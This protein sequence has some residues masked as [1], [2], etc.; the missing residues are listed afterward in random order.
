MRKVLNK[1]MNL[2]SRGYITFSDSN[3]KCQ[4]LQIKMSGGEQKSDIEYIEPYGFTSRP[5]DGAEAVALFLDGDKSHGV[6]LTTGDRRYRITSLKKGEVAIY[7]DEGDAIIF[8]R[9]NEI[10]VKTKKFIVNADDAIELNTKNLVVSAS[11]GTQF[12]TPLFKSSG[13]IADKTST[14]SN[15]RTIYNG[16]THNETSTVTHNPNQKMG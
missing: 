2:V 11:S 6:I 12:N 16:H 15:I 5:L 7:T 4:T 10:N 14:I 3:S 9:N 1:I 8:N 13:E